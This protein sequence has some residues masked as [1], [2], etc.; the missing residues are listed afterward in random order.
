M[1]NQ[2]P[3]MKPLKNHH[4]IKHRFKMKNRHGMRNRS[5]L[6]TLLSLPLVAQADKLVIPANAPSAFQTECGACHLAFP[7]G[8]LDAQGWRA[9]MARLDHHYGDNASLDE[10]TRRTIEN[11]MVRHAG[12]DRVRAPASATGEPPRLTASPWFKRKHHEVPVTDWQSPKVKSPANCGACHSRAA[13]G[14]YRE[15]E[16]VM[17]D[18]RPW[19]EQD[20]D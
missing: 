11:F 17:P 19:E 14:S 2:A 16:I 15:R 20:D 1:S 8:L 18:G 5:L 3:L 9:V 10:P 12:G 13:E 6:A 4:G 7:P